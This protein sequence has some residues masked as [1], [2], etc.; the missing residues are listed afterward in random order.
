MKRY[1]AFDTRGVFIRRVFA[2]NA[3]EALVKAKK[4]SGRRK[5]ESVEEEPM[6]QV[7]RGD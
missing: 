5:V 2:M 1:A 7:T 3:E 4:L 6:A